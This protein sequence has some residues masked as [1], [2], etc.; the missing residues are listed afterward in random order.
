M[1]VGWASSS[2]GD[3]YIGPHGDEVPIEDR[4]KDPAL[5][6]SLKAADGDDMAAAAAIAEPSS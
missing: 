5:T 4:N 3:E 2:Y 1:Y 6:A